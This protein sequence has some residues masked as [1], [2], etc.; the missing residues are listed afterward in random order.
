MK[1][2]EF[3]TMA[4]FEDESEVTM[5]LR[6]EGVSPKMLALIHQVCD[7][8]ETEAR[9]FG[10]F[11]STLQEWLPGRGGEIMTVTKAVLEAGSQ[12]YLVQIAVTTL[13]H[14]VP[15]RKGSYPGKDYPKTV[16]SPSRAC[17]N[18][19]FDVLDILPEKEIT[20]IG[21]RN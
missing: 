14:G 15:Y 21:Q 1:K 5:S 9:E 7:E 8:S 10:A 19:L 20:G 3:F 17:L 11:D 13:F 12:S 16:I 4:I 2:K 6:F 18:R